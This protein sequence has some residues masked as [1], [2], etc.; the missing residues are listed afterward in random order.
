MPDD[1]TAEP[2]VV[3]PPIG[4]LFGAG[5]T[6]IGR[7]GALVG[8]GWAAGGASEGRAV[9]VV[10][11]TFSAAGTAS[12]TASG[13]RCSINVLPPATTTIAA[14]IFIQFGTRRTAGAPFPLGTTLAGT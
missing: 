13:A 1:A 9:T 11:G 3:A 2:V 4:P 14:A 8:A 5:V 10:A 7:V 12:V 6:A